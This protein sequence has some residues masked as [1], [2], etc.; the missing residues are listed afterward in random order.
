MMDPALAR[1]LAAWDW[2]P[3]VVA[4]CLGLAAVSWWATRAWSWRAALFLAGDLILLLALVSPL[5]ALSDTYLF[6]AH[7]IQHLLLLEVVPL[8]L[9]LGTP[10]GVF[11]RLLKW[12]PAALAER[13]LGRPAVAWCIGA[14]TIWLWHLPPLYNA[15]LANEGIH[16]VEH[17]CFLLSATIFWWPIVGPDSYRPAPWWGLAYLLLGAVANS[18]LAILLTFAPAGLYPAYLH[19]DDTLG[20]L[21]LLRGSLGI[22]PQVDQELGGVIMWIPGGWIYLLAIVGTFA[23]W[24]SAS[25]AEEAAWAG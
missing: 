22:S 2:Q 20:I 19:P 1:L 17:L 16:I 15:T 14:A 6:S 7:M 5:D 13:A 25:D 11:Y 18:V 9:L 21:P 4:G 10:P 3:S 23:R 8:L 12:R 24:Y